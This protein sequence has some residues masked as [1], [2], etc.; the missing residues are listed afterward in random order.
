MFPLNGEFGTKEIKNRSAQGIPRIVRVA[1]GP[2]NTANGSYEFFGNSS[3]YIE[4]PNSEGGALDVRHSMTMLCWL[5]YDGRYGPIFNYGT[6]KGKGVVLRVSNGKLIAHFRKRDYL[7]TDQLKHT[8]L[9]G[10]WKFVGASYDNITSTAKLWVDGDQVLTKHFE[11]SLELGTQ[12]SVR[13]GVRTSDNGHFKGRIAMMQIY[14]VA[15]TQEQIQTILEKTPRP[16]KNA[17][18]PLALL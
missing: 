6:S 5:H 12:D 2:D 1:P 13:M 14:N 16:G 15:L 3:S 7:K 9:A 18:R 8:T 4:F 11:E 10:G 17:S